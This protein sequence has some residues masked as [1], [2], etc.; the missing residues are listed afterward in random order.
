MGS[1]SDY[2]ENKI[3]DHIVGKT[4]YTMP[5]AYVALST[6][7]PLDTGAGLAE[8]SGGA[9]ARVATAGGDWNAA[10]SGA[11]DNANAITFPTATAS[12]GTISHFAIM[13]AATS[14]N[15]LA[16]GALTASKVIGNGDTAT[17]AAGDI[18]ITLD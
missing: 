1:F 14:G 12:W 9:Y 6:A 8:P 10:A 2:L 17:F 7:D 4:S 16:H 18:D 3:L 11:I 5:T 15:M 13:D